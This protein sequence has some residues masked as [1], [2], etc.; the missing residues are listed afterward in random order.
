MLFRSVETV[1][2]PK[3]SVLW[4]A[5][6]PGDFI[7]GYRVKAPYAPRQAAEVAMHFQP[8]VRALLGFRNAIMRPFGLTGARAGGDTI[9]IF[10]VVQETE[11]EL[12]LGFDDKHLDFRISI[13]SR[14]GYV[15]CATWVHRHNWL[16]RIYLL[17]VM[18]VHIL[19]SKQMMARVGRHARSELAPPPE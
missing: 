3:E 12:V 4:K 14:N 6:T 2:L 7:D 18:P 8:W 16:G 10:P 9:A 1:S 19:L 17:V 11:T 5:Y 15:H 13:L